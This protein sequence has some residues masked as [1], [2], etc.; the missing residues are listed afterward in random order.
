MSAENSLD[1]LQ[2]V[3]TGAALGAE[4]RGVD[5]AR[6]APEEV[7]RAMRGAWT[8][9][10]VLLFRDQELTEEQHLDATRVFGEPMVGAA[11]A[12]YDKAGKEQSWAARHPEITVVHNL[13]ENGSPVQENDSL[14]SGEVVWHSDN[15]YVEEPP[16]GSLLYGRVLPPSGGNT[17][18][19]NQYLAYETL[20]D[21]VKEKIEGR[22]AV[23]DS[24]RNSAGT[25]RPGVRM[26]T[27]PSEVPGPHHPL[28]RTHPAS[29]RR[30]LY[31]GRRRAW[32]SQYIAGMEEAE[33]EELLDFL[34][35]HACRPELVWAHEWR[36]GDMLL[37][38]NRCAMHYREP[39]AGT[40]P[41]VMH[42]T[43]IKGDQPV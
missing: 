42:R 33:S 14:G 17:C 37:W 3:P 30:A 35:E 34:W 29:G 2:V 41:R 7:A 32:P 23:H 21:E 9:H 15:S 13:D 10:L 25:L 43:Q 39:H 22:A 6:P 8:E 26:P 28:A 4:I 40:H 38:D 24:S 12:Y 19:S 1:R 31:L 11:K 20:P 18:F 5:F 16:A 36:P 27:K